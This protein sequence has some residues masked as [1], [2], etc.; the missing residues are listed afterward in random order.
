MHTMRSLALAVLSL[1]LMAA[2]GHKSVR[3][4]EHADVVAAIAE[5]KRRIGDREVLQ[6]CGGLRRAPECGQGRD[7]H[8]W[9]AWRR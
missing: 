4:D 7:R 5:M 1:P 6:Q 2:A 8:R 3:A 9:R